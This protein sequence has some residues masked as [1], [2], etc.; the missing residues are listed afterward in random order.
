M[1][2][3]TIISFLSLLMFAAA[4]CSAQEAQGP[5]SAAPAQSKKQDQRPQFTHEE[6]VQFVHTVQTE[7]A[8]WKE[9]INSVDPSALHLDDKTTALIE[10]EKKASLL[11]LDEIGTLSLPTSEK[12]TAPDMVPEFVLYTLLDMIMYGAESLS[13][14]LVYN[15]RGGAAKAGELLQIQREALR[16]DETLFK[17]IVNRITN[18]AHSEKAGG[19]Q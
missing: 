11:A 8:N 1:K 4:P 6:V 16:A 19:C 10:K 12:N 15:S 2:G 18:I 7:A 17:E 14:T 3:I 5:L 9:T 13:N